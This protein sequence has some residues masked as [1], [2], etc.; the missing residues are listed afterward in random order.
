[1]DSAAIGETAPDHKP[2]ARSARVGGHIVDELIAERAPGLTGAP[3][4]PL[5]RPGLY[6]LLDYGKAR[7][8]AEAIVDL[9]GRRTLDYVSDLLELKVEARGLE[10]VPHAGRLVVICNHPTGI[11]DGLAV[12]QALKR[13]RDDL[14]F[15]ANADALRV[16][17]RLD[18]VIIPVE[19]V[20]AKRTRERTRRTLVETRAAFQAERAIVVFPAGRIARREPS[21]LLTDP[22]WMPTALSLARRHGAPVLPVHVTGPWSTLF[23]LFNRFSPELRDITLFHELLNKRGGEFSLTVGRPIAT[24]AFEGD[25]VGATLALKHYIERVLPDDADA[26]F[27]PAPPGP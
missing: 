15:Y 23:H 14:I 3:F 2:T 22:A 4:W 20:E 12:Y 27:N 7:R 11:A 8:M 26:D 10:R 6:R 25:D 19:W 13:V 18:E 9:P 24:E 5:V 1:M 16:S 21:G 17:A